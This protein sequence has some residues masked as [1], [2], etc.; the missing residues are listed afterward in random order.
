MTFDQAGA[1]ARGVLPVRGGDAANPLSSF[2]AP[3][4]LLATLTTPGAAQDQPPESKPQSSRDAA[5]PSN[6]QPAKKP[7]HVYTDDD[8]ASTRPS[9]GSGAG[10]DVSSQWTV[11]SFFSKDPVTAKDIAALQKF[12]T[13]SYQFNLRQTKAPV[14]NLYLQHYKD[15]TFAGRGEWEERLFAGFECTRSAQGNYVKELDSAS[16]DPEYHDLLTSTRLS[17]SELRKMGDLRAHL[18]AG[19]EPVRVCNAK[20]DV[21]RKEG[22]QRADEWLKTHPSK[23]N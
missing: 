19:W 16:R 5:V 7:K 8:F 6:V 10:I 23:P 2:L 21:I 4:S 9:G 13:P 18:I 3:A 14:A 11:E 20:F 15:L 17:D 22:W 12:I 1:P